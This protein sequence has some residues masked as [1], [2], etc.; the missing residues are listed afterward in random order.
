MPLVTV[1]DLL[2][3]AFSF[4]CSTDFLDV[5]EKAVRQRQLVLKKFNVPENLSA[6]LEAQLAVPSA[7]KDYDALAI[8][9]YYYVSFGYWQAENATKLFEVSKMDFEDDTLKT[10]FFFRSKLSICFDA[11]H[12]RVHIGYRCRHAAVALVSPL[13][14]HELLLAPPRKSKKNPEGMACNRKKLVGT[15]DRKF[16]TADDADGQWHVLVEMESPPG[17]AGSAIAEFRVSIKTRC[18]VDPL[19]VTS[20]TKLP[21]VS[22]D[23][24]DEDDSDRD[25]DM[26]HEGDIAA[27]ALRF[28]A[29]RVVRGQMD[30]VPLPRD[31]RTIALPAAFKRGPSLVSGETKPHGLGPVESS[32]PAS[33]RLTPL[34]MS[35]NQTISSSKFRQILFFRMNA[36][37]MDSSLVTSICMKASV[38]YSKQGDDQSSVQV[39]ADETKLAVCS[40]PHGGEN[41]AAGNID[42]PARESKIIC[43][44]AEFVITGSCGADNWER[45]FLHLTFPDPC[46]FAV[47]LREEHSGASHLVR[48]CFNTPSLELPTRESTAKEWGLAPGTDFEAFVSADDCIARRRHRVGVFSAVE[49][50]EEVITVRHPNRIV[51]GSLQRL[52]AVAYQAS[53]SGQDE[54]PLDGFEE[55]NCKAWWLV[56]RDQYPCFVY[57]VR[58]AVETATSCESAAC[59]IFY[60]RDETEWISKP[61]SDGSAVSSPGS[62]VASKRDRLPMPRPPVSNSLTGEG[63]SVDSLALFEE[64]P[65]QRSHSSALGFT[66]HYDEFLGSGAVGR[67][68]KAFDN[69]LGMTVAVKES[70]YSG[71]QSE[72]ANTTQLEFSVL[73]SLSH[74]SIVK[75][76]AL[77]VGAAVLRVFM[78]W[79]PSGSVLALLKKTRFRL[80]EG[81]IRRYIT[82]AL[83]GLA[84]L[85]EK[86]ILHLD[87]KPA[88][89][90]V[91]ADGSLKLADFGATKWLAAGANS[92]T[93]QRVIGT[94]A[95]MS[96]EIISTGKYSK[97]SDMWAIGCCITEMASGEMPWSHLAPE[98]R[99]STVPLMFFIGNAK[100][101][102]HA[103]IIPGHLSSQLKAIVNRCFSLHLHIRPTA[104]ELLEDPYFTDESLP[105]DAEHPAAFAEAAA[106]AQ[107]AKAADH[108]P[109]GQQESVT[110]LLN[111]DD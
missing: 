35:T 59:H 34:S 91:A 68:F 38:H 92:M 32:G 97:A 77:E 36:V 11:L 81:V 21:K 89:M 2:E 103:P 26:D 71:A 23:L 93:T 10:V 7:S 85:H 86:S 64:F 39:W 25:Q 105:V 13:A 80:H 57:G 70:P 15:D 94:P 108:P 101:P 110:S 30:P 82:A 98:I 6:A 22:R 41:Y 29:L 99:Y 102:N 50:N 55:G 17:Q 47:Q 109:K 46:N 9:F 33:L 5:F 24:S 78:E 106:R 43:V 52:N 37:N 79:M 90:L 3:N 31:P 65:A 49:S 87:L 42:L 100:P 1:R 74:E 18:E 111:T 63:A 58:I 14:L 51:Y 76:Y 84:Y 19:V 95:Y 53:R 45:S 75:V 67:V 107:E 48:Y 16:S 54:V 73:T 44:R 20:I 83:R 8:C 27:P 96:P 88:N 40:Q 4:T 66:I 56:A 104:Q 12:I 72:D 69:A 60:S 61:R 28:S 62:S